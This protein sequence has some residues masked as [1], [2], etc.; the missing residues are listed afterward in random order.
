MLLN[1][2]DYQATIAKPL[3]RDSIR[4][5][6]FDISSIVLGLNWIYWFEQRHPEI[7]ASWPRN[8]D[9]KHAQN[10][11]P[12]NVAHF[13]KLLKDIY[14]AYPNLPP[15]HVWNIDEKGVQFGRGRKCLKKYY[16]L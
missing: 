16:H 4:S 5:L 14:D 2:I 15:K 1:W 11:N 3:N 7:C 10:F 9:L 8:L 13:Y 12:M 6:I